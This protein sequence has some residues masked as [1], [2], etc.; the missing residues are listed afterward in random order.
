[1]LSSWK[2]HPRSTRRNGKSDMAK[3]AR[4]DATQR[5]FTPKLAFRLR[6]MVKDHA[7][8]ATVLKNQANRIMRTI[9]S[10]GLEIEPADSE[11]R[12]LWIRRIEHTGAYRKGAMYYKMF[13]GKV[14]PGE[15]PDG[16][17]A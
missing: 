17:G 8:N 4:P 1:M 14:W 2:S 10:L 7:L 11:A 16:A 3:R 6:S 13:Q 12:K 5:R 9:T 15:E